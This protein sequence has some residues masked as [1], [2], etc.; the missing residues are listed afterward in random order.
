MLFSG[1]WG[2]LS[3]AL[4]IITNADK[5]PLWCT[6][7]CLERECGGKDQKTGGHVTFQWLLANALKECV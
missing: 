7:L 2:D 3:A 4:E 6:C 5:D 1:V